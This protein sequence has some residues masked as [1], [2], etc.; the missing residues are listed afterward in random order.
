[1]TTLARTLAQMGWRTSEGAPV[2]REPPFGAT[3]VVSRRTP[4]GTDEFLLLHRSHHGADYEGDWAWGPPAGAR[5]PGEP[6]DT[7]ARRE[8][9]EETGLELEPTATPCGDCEWVVFSAVAPPDAEVRLSREHDRHAWLPLE[10]AAARCRPASVAEQLRA[11][12]A[13]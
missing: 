3:V 8:L 13:R 2:S 1:V 5:L 6:V 9:L 7:C 11:T 12:A 4:R 10:R